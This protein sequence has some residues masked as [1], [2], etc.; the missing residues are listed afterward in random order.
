MPSWLS[1]SEGRKGV[2][3]EYDIAACVQW[4]L[5]KERAKKLAAKNHREVI[6]HETA[7]KPQ[8]ANDKAEC[9]LFD[10]DVLRERHLEWCD[11][12]GDA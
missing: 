4:T 2:V 7:R 1:S 6:E 5:E 12:A 10:V 11:T 3:G 9:R 8:L